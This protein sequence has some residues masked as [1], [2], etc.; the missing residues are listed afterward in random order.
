[1]IQ[2]DAHISQGQKKEEILKLT[3]YMH[4]DKLS[5][6]RGSMGLHVLIEI[7]WIIIQHVANNTK[8]LL[9]NFSIV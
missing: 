9:F 4:V 6:G 1:M 7:T 5:Y 8:M 2:K 3:L